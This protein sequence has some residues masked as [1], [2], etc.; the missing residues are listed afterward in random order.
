MDPG[1]DAPA[2]VLRRMKSGNI[3]GLPSK[4]VHAT[5]E[6]M[7]ARQ[8]AAYADVVEGALSGGGGTMLATLH[9][10]RGVSLHPV[11]PRQGENFGDDEY[12]AMSA[13]L[14][15]TFRILA[16]IH[17]RGE[18]ALIFVE[19]LD[20]QYR[21]GI[22]IKRRFRW[23]R[24][25]AGPPNR[26]EPDFDAFSHREVHARF[27]ESAAA[28]LRRATR[29]LSR[30]N[31]QWGESTDRFHRMI[32]GKDSDKNAITIDLELSLAVVTPPSRRC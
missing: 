5:R 3:V 29:P 10:L 7:P 27:C 15:A 21:L 18:K 20:M 12:C 14:A 11:D 2:I 9:R 28:R 31:S 17:R 23:L 4:N 8:A 1:D 16:E 19:S 26:D 13:R 6:P 30:A 22:L 24:S 32:Q 25:L